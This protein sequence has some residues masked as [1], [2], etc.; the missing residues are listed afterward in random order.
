MQL[1]DIPLKPELSPSRNAQRYYKLYTKAKAAEEHSSA[2]LAEAKTELKYLETVLDSITRAASYSDIS[3]IREELAEQ[4]YIPSLRSNKKQKAKKS[5]PME[6]VSSDGYTI[7]VGRNNKQ[8]DELTIKTAYSTDIWFH[9]KTIPGSHTVVR[10]NG[11]SELPDTT[12][13]EAASI[14]AYFSKAQNSSGVP[15]DYTAIKN[16]KKPNGSKP[17]FV[18]YETNST[19]YVTPDEKLVEK[20]RKA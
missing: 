15:V 3:E 13:L 11:Q 6:F 12:I 8:N 5:A 18:I 10:T 7:L 20:L 17:G 4:G 19:V 16:V 2:Q 1:F 14:A 9:T